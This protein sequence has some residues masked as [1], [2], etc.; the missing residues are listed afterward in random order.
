MCRQRPA[1][2]MIGL[3]VVLGILALVAAMFFAFLG[4]VRRGADRSRSMANLQQI[5]IGVHNFHDSNRRLPPMVGKVG[6]ANGTAH[7]HLL[8][9]IE[10]TPLHRSGMENMARVRDTVVPI[11]VD[12]LDSSVPPRFVYKD[13]LATTN[14]PGNWMIFGDGSLTLA[15]IPDGTSNTVM[16]SQRYQLCGGQPTA[17]AYDRL[18]Y[19]AP[20]YAFYSRARFQVMP[21]ADQC[22]PALPQSLAPEGILIGMGDGSVRLVSDRVSPQTWSFATD[23]ADGHPIGPDF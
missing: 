10:Q 21:A 20:M 11:F 14:Y 19:W 9:F 3:L 6:E 23:P 5:A 7:F 22:D 13:W 2:T 17:W 8:P 18:H 12:H 1:F 4:Q 15:N 16:L